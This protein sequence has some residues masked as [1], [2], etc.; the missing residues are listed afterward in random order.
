LHI[1]LLGGLLRCAHLV[2]DGSGALRFLQCAA[3]RRQRAAIDLA[4]GEIA[5][6]VRGS[7]LQELAIGVLG[8]L[9][10]DARVVVLVRAGCTRPAPAS[11]RTISARGRADPWDCAA[12]ARSHRRL[13]LSTDVAAR[14]AE[15]VLERAGPRR[16]VGLRRCSAVHAHAR[17]LRPSIA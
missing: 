13:R 8:V 1:E 3:G 16:A 10:R 9:L 15:R 14:D 6:L 12:H 5:R 11:E 4:I 17:E 7:A 2:V